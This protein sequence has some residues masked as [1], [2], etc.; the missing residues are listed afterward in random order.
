MIALKSF[1]RDF[2]TK[3]G[4]LTFDAGKTTPIAEAMMAIVLLDHYLRQRAQNLDVH[5]E[6]QVI[7]AGF[8]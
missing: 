7:P 8:P 2:I 6:S 4:A 3:L 1:R 5:C